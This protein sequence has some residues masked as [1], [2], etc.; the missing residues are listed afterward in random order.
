[1]PGGVWAV[2]VDGAPGSTTMADSYKIEPCGTTGSG[3]HFVG[4][5]HSIWGADVAAAVVSQTQPVDVSAYGG[6]SFVMKSTTANTLIFKVQN[7]YSQPP[8]GRC[9]EVDPVDACYSGY[10]KIVSI[11]AS[12]TTPIVVRWAEL[13]QQTWG[14]R[15]PGSVTFN[16]RDLISVAFAFDQNVDFDVCIDDVKFV[17]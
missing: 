2:D 8:C 6:M 9:V 12:A 7:S 5:G 10:V 16:P 1:M 4:H 3:L 14:Y 15:P 17:P 11:P 13:V